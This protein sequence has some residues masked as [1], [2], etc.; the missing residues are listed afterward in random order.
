MSRINKNLSPFGDKKKSHLPVPSKSPNNLLI[1]PHKS[2]KYDGKMKSLLKFPDNYKSPYKDRSPSRDASFCVINKE[3]TPSRTTNRDDQ[4]SSI[5]L[6][7]ILEDMNMS[8]YRNLF[9]TH[10]VR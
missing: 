5:A 6:D 8:K 2:P 1:S 4:R 9:A 10:E 3:N 7:M